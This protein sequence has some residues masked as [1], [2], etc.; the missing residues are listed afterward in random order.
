MHPIWTSN[1]TR[2]SFNEKLK[3]LKSINIGS[4]V[5][6]LAASLFY[7]LCAINSSARYTAREAL[8]HPWITRKKH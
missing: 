7:K 3:N 6:P 2:E 1:D 8:N 5:S 4:E